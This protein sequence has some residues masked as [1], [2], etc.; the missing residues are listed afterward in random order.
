M[1]GSAAAGDDV[2]MPRE[3]IESHHDGVVRAVLL[4]IQ[5][6]KKQGP[7]TSRTPAVPAD[8]G[9]AEGDEDT[10]EEASTLGA[11]H[12]A[13]VDGWQKLNTQDIVSRVDAFLA[14]IAEGP[15]TP[16]DRVFVSLAVNLRP[17]LRLH[18]DCADA[19]V[20]AFASFYR[21]CSKL[22][23]VLLRLFRSLVVHGFCVPPESRG[24][25]DGD[26]GD[27]QQGG[28]GDGTGM[29]EGQGSEDVSNQL[30]DEEQLLG[31]QGQDAPE[32][33]D[34]SEPAPDTGM[35]M[36][37][38]FD[39]SL[40]SMEK[41][42][43]DGLNDK[44][45]GEEKEEEAERE[46]GQVGDD[47]DENVLDEKMWDDEDEGEDSDEDG[48]EE[49]KR[50]EKFEKDAA[51][52]GEQ[53][54][55]DEV[56]TKDD[57]DD[58]DANEEESGKNDEAAKEDT[59]EKDAPEPEKGGADDEQDMPGQED[60]DGDEP[61]INAEDD[62][63][64]ED[65]HAGVQPMEDDDGEAGADDEHGDDD[66]EELAEDMD[67]GGDDQD[68]EDGG[69]E[70]QEAQPADDVLQPEVVEDEAEDEDDDVN[71]VQSGTAIDMDVEE[72]GDGS[73][74]GDNGDE[75][76]K[77]PARVD[78]DEEG[79]DSAQQQGATAM[80]DGDQGQGQG[81]EDD[82]DAETKSR[83]SSGKQEEAPSE[84]DE[85]KAPE[86]RPDPDGGGDNNN[87]DERDVPAKGGSNEEEG[88]WKHVPQSDEEESKNKA[89]DEQEHEDPRGR[90]AAD[91]NNPLRDPGQVAEDWQRRLDMVEEQLERPDEDKAD[92]APTVAADEDVNDN[93]EENN[94]E[95]P[96]PAEGQKY[97]FAEAGE[98]HD[99]QVLA[100]EK[101]GAVGEQPTLEEEGQDADEEQQAVAGGQDDGSAETPVD[102]DHELV[103]NDDEDKD[104]SG[105]KDDGV[106]ED[107]EASAVNVVPRLLDQQS[108]DQAASS[109]DVERRRPDASEPRIVSRGN[110]DQHDEDEEGESKLDGP[111][112]TP[113]EQSRRMEELRSELKTS[114]EIWRQKQKEEGSGGSGANGHE[115]WTKLNHL[116][117]DSPQ[118]LCEQLRLILAP[119][120]ASKMQGDYRT[121]KRINMRKVISFIASNYKK[122]KI[123]LR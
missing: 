63:E 100:P 26:D 102:P 116:I 60:G 113:E 85:E 80:E 13:L 101:D 44:D 84:E 20:A 107:D 19:V 43:D 61:Q 81:D 77:E 21:A 118:Q 98:A 122:D 87:D 114:L 6:L 11:S 73:E 117:G 56:R 108:A 71:E 51:I 47:D 83:P 76:E 112:L 93:D 18:L 94:T 37:N 16:W 4:G 53:G 75:D 99:D 55:T 106:D 35:D 72:E 22:L 36:S 28:Q 3:V 90:S 64:Y 57:D 78:M 123:W 2:A 9:A 1:E 86:N 46:M 34:S 29:G 58:D 92:D 10:A 121:G 111:P 33:K 27:S 52:D 66:D 96:P 40:Q 70:G 91:E 39:G 12:R 120:L 115:I 89:N 25:E 109:L 8:R 103:G 69:D 105:G 48:G 41:E 104:E 82:Q 15:P 95:K 24:K 17:L 54:R 67:L 110:E 97:E 68:A 32:Q 119:M 31:L 14:C 23:Y 65:H 7:D 38:D 88:T 79:A 50:P 62:Q 49:E 45:E 42:E 30:E 74:D 59:K 5:R